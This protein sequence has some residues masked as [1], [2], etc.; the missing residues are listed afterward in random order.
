M[1]QR[2]NPEMLRR[3]R[4][5]VQSSDSVKEYWANT[6]RIPELLEFQE[7]MKRLMACAGEQARNHRITT[8]DHV[9]LVELVAELADSWLDLIMKGGV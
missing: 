5:V 9:R 4:A 6:N 3:M 1:L 8:P 7:D 2:P